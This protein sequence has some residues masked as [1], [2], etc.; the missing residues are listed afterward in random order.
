MGTGYVTLTDAA[1]R[2]GLTQADVEG[3]FKAGAIAGKRIGEQLLLEAES[4]AKLARAM[5]RAGSSEP[6]VATVDPTGR[7]SGISGSRESK[8]G[9]SLDESFGDDDL[10]IDSAIFEEEVALEELEVPAEEEEL[11]VQEI[12]LDDA[13]FETQLPQDECVPVPETAGALSAPRARGDRRRGASALSVVSLLLWVFVLAGGGAAAYHYGDRQHRD[14]ARLQ[15]DV[16]SLRHA[17]ADV[18]QTQQVERNR[19]D[20][21][22][23]ATG[24]IDELWEL[25][26][27]TGDRLAELEQQLDVRLAAAGQ[28]QDE[29]YARL[30]EQLGTFDESLRRHVREQIVDLA[31]RQEARLDTVETRLNGGLQ[32][33]ESGLTRQRELLV[34]EIERLDA[35]Y[36]QRLRRT[37]LLASAET[38]AGEPAT[39]AAASGRTTAAELI[40]LA[41]ESENTLDY[42]LGGEVELAQFAEDL[43]D[44]VSIPVRLDV[45][46][47]REESIDPSHPLAIELRPNARLASA[48][49]L[50][51]EP[52]ELDWIVRDD[53][54]LITTPSAAESYLFT[55]VYDVSDLLG[56]PQQP[57]EDDRDLRYDYKTLADLLD[58]AIGGLGS[59]TVTEFG[60]I[61]SSG[62]A[63]IH[64]FDGALIILG[65]RRVHERV[66]A[67]LAD[68]RQVRRTRQGADDDSQPRFVVETYRVESPQRLSTFS[69]PGLG[70]FSLTP[71]L[72]PVPTPSRDAEATPADPPDSEPDDAFAKRIAEAIPKL[73]D[74]ESWS[75]GGAAIEAVPGAVIVRHTPDVQA[76]IRRLLQPFAPPGTTGPLEGRTQPGPYGGLGGGTIPGSGYGSGLFDI[77]PEAGGPAA[78]P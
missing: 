55:H 64:A 45:A 65:H 68:L 59:T 69:S 53:V 17:V 52:H 2:L 67:T 33:I 34:A 35:L 30:D 54:L 46:A 37:L 72:S 51:L 74:P 26:Q 32:S 77:R 28:A 39:E 71:T 66:A 19:L 27:R 13:E 4:V 29:R 31:D 44:Y 8:S 14:L 41:L 56:T 76:R 11:A 50:A 57:F 58:A 47:L 48:L 15:A 38:G 70:T 75:E 49:N 20:D 63:Q 18:L 42:P 25:L 43:E 3:L 10:A 21:T 6:A 16:V 12:P 7:D 9:L 73:V 24:Q 78:G 22:V 62:E 40:H 23:Q 61:G 60:S 36:Q 1:R 5:A